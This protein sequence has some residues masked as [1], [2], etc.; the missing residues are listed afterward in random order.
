[1]SKGK[2]KNSIW[3][4][5]VDCI[6]IYFSNIDKF[7]LYMLFPVLGQIIGLI[8]AFGLGVGFADRIAEKATSMSNA[9]LYVFLLTIPGLLIFVKAFWDYM[10]A[11]VALN[12]MTEGALTTCKVYDFQSHREVATRRAGKYILFLMAI[13]ILSCIATFC[14]IIP[15][16]GLIPPLILWIYFILVFQ[17][18]T[19]EQDLSIKEY[20]VKSMELVKGN[21]AKTFCLMLI[22]GFF[23]IY[24][25]TMGVTVIF[26]YLNLTDITCSLFDIVG[27]SLPLEYI[28]KALR[29]INQPVITVEMISKSIFTSIVGIIVA[30]FTLPVRSIAYTLWYMGLSD[31]KG[32]EIETLTQNKPKKQRKTGKKSKAEVEDNE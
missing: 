3:L 23:S 11:Y 2:I 27:K 18:F 20:F 30:E 5:L 15:V 14:C 28:N 21:W 22:L 29:Y 7:I 16:F 4:V 9:L 24:I 17:V 6:K 31:A 32:N 10:V 8:L 25:I 26:D 1:M 19:F 13:G 12:S